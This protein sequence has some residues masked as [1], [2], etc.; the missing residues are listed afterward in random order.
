MKQQTPA[1]TASKSDVEKTHK[2]NSTKWL[3]HC[4]QKLDLLW[5]SYRNVM[6]SVFTA[7]KIVIGLFHRSKDKDAISHQQ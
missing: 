2:K 1:A 4:R 7:F 3:H 6:M 5:T